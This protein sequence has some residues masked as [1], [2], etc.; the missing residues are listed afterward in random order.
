M[1]RQNGSLLEA[2]F[3]CLCDACQMSPLTIHRHTSCIHAQISIPRVRCRHGEARSGTKSKDVSDGRRL[4]NTPPIVGRMQWLQ[5]VE[6]GERKEGD[7]QL[8]HR[9]HW[10]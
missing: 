1:Q 6:E 8:L 9:L 7:M 2:S 4:L 5:G 10:T 3:C